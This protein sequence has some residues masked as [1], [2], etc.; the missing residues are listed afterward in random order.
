M[1]QP[2]NQPSFGHNLH[3]GPDAGCAC[4]DPHQ[5]KVAVLEC[6]EDPAKHFHLS[7]RPGKA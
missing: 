5:S 2:I 4:A 3:P 1:T 7:E 6:F